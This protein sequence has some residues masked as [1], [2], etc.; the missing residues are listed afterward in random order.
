MKS[1]LLR[2]P[3]ADD[4]DAV[5]LAYRTIR[6]AILEGR[7]APS[8]VLSQVL[9]ARE[10]GI[11]RTPLREALRQL[12]TEGLVTGDF[13]RRLR[14]TSLDLDDFDQIYACRIALEPIAIRSTLPLLDDEGRA[15]LVA[16]VDGMDATIAASDLVAFRGHHRDFHLGMCALAGPRIVRMLSDLWDHSERYRRAY[17]HIES[18]EPD[19]VSRERLVASQVEHRAILRA[20]LDRDGDE[21]SRLLVAHLT[22]TIDNVFEEQA[23]RATP[24]RATLAIGTSTASPAPAA[25]SGRALDGVE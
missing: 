7:L 13:N 5:E 19:D 21:S 11:S 9:L 15:G 4:L 20:A 3:D 17:L 24:R 16:A 2:P 18:S 23:R 8:A 12:A 25:V 1:D 10:L 22:R 6:A 14:V